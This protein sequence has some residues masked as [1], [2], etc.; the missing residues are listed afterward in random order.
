MVPG[1]TEKRSL[2]QEL[3]SGV[4][5]IREQSEGRRTLQIRKVLLIEPEADRTSETPGGASTS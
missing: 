2:F 5:A 4:Q 3:M 1:K